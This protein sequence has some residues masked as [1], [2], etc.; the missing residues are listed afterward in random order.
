MP[1]FALLRRAAV[2]SC[3]LFLG[4]VAL[5]QISAGL[6]GRILDA[7]GAVVAGAQVDLTAADTGVRQQ[8]V[9]SAAGDYLF[10]NLNPGAY[11]ID[12][13]A[14]GF[15]HLQRSGVTVVLGQTARADLAL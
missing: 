7:S 13:S 10:S 6:R 14:A 12:V 15:E 9:S 2:L 3:A 5:A 11:S 1:S 8:T 4:P